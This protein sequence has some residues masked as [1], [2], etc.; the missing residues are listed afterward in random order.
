[1]KRSTAILFSALL[2]LLFGTTATLAQV[3]VAG[4][5]QRHQQHPGSMGRMVSRDDLGFAQ[6]VWTRQFNTNEYHAYFNAWDP[7]MEDFMLPTGG[8]IVD[9]FVQAVAGSQTTLPSGFCFP[10]FHGHPTPQSVLAA[11]AAIDFLPLAGAFTAFS[12]AGLQTVPKGYPQVTHTVNGDLHMISREM[13]S[14]TGEVQRLFYSRGEPIFEFGFGLEIDWQNVSGN[15]QFLVLDSAHTFA[16]VIAASLTGNRLAVAYTRHIDHEQVPL[17]PFNTDVFIRRSEDNG[18][19]WSA[20]QNITNFIQPDHAAYCA[21]AE[22]NCAN[23]DTLRAFD[24]ISALFDDAGT[25]HIA[26][27]TIGYYHW[28]EDGETHIRRDRAML[29]HWNDLDNQHR[30]IAESWDTSPEDLGALRGMGTEQA[31]VEHPSLAFNASNDLLYCAYLK[32]DTAQHLPDESL[33]NA[34][35]F[36]SKFTNG[37]WSEGE[38]VT[39]TTPDFGLNQ[40]EQELS[41]AEEIIDDKLYCQYLLHQSGDYNFALPASPVNFQRVDLGLINFGAAIPPRSLHVTTPVCDT[42]ATSTVILQSVSDTFCDSVQLVMSVSS[43]RGIDMLHVYRDGQHVGVFPVEDPPPYQWTD[44]QPT[45]DESHY[46]IYGWSRSCGFTESS[47]TLIGLAG[48]LPAMVQNFAAS[49]N[50]FAEIRLTWSSNPVSDSVQQ[51]TLYRNNSVFAS[52]SSIMNEYVDLTGVPGIEYVFG[53][54]AV[55]RCG[56]GPLA[57]DNGGVIPV[58]EGHATLVLVTAGPPDWDYRLDWV[59][60]CVNQLIIRSLC[61][62]TTASFV[63]DPD[64]WHVESIS[65]SVVFSGG[66]L[67]GTPQS[68]T[69]FRLTND[70]PNC[71]GSG[72]WSSGNGTGTIGGP[73][74]IGN[75]PSLPVEFNVSVFP[76]PFN[77]TT[78]FE[79]AIPRAADTRVLVY[80]LK[81]QLVRELSLG[82]LH[83]GYHS[84]QFVANELP[85]G[86]YFAKVL[87]GSFH[88]THKLMLLK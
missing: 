63:E 44:L 39:I 9:V 67:C 18:T 66:P 78:N 4:E 59:D 52:V 87:S 57:T 64:F 51:Y 23:R 22:I 49:R 16:H 72:V 19:N 27:T 60:G 26:Y 20:A 8:G 58:N 1:M 7:V 76:N 15:Q 14:D 5:T 11:A 56:A 40:N 82:Q 32:Y 31:I 74:P 33:I 54:R 24:Q 30:L 21:G 3:Y 68:V 55:N 65:D 10:A 88:S 86:M 50:H 25:L 6:V 70:D 62:G 34:D 83:S 38:H 12:P 17:E 35:V 48:H 80:N 37:A 42:I 2:S 77:P 81:G 53:I 47:D 85:S 36:V 13:Q 41:V 69:G 84:V 71:I 29:W 46:W 45:P 43:T 61:P 79:I 75:Q 73:L 28:L